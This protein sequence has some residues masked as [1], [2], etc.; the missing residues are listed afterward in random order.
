MKKY[1]YEGDGT[2]DESI[3]GQFSEL[4]YAVTDDNIQEG[5]KLRVKNVF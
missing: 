2:V 1:L 4:Y 3:S 5:I